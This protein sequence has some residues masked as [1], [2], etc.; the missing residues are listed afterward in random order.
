MSS[1][2]SIRPSKPRRVL[3]LLCMAAAGTIGLVTFGIM[4]RA[5]SMQ[6][7]KIWTD[8]QAIP[9]VRLV[10][11]ERGSVEEQLILPGTVNGFNTGTL[12]ARA[13]GYVT[14]WHKDIGAHVKKD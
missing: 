4:D 6:E 13:S 11:P 12:F 3:L 5:K 7:V 14:V 8:E 1:D 9:T 2:S 10:Q